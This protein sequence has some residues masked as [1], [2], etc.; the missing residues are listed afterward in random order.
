MSLPHAVIFDVDG[1]LID[2]YQ[3]HFESWRM[4]C[5]ERG[6]TMSEQQFVDTFGRTSREVARTLWKDAAGSDDDVADMDRRKEAYFRQIIDREF[7][8]MAGAAELIDQLQDAGFS[9]AVGSSAPPE[10]VHQILEHL[11]RKERFQGIITGNDVTR[12]KPDPQ[13]FLLG[14]QAMRVDPSRC[15]VVE[16]AP[17][18]VAAAH[19]AGMQCVALASTGR[20]PETLREAEV[21]VEQLTE[22]TPQTFL[23][24]LATDAE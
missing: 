9:L 16:D 11:Q 1:V 24:L 2:S 10:N 3:A 17:A 5:R 20:S 18:G 8:A 13:V 4:L 23:T 7:P 12:G 14:A 19:A 21:V 6:L 15:V 22:L